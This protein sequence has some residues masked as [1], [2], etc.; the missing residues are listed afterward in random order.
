MK[1]ND[2]RVLRA[3]N[4]E[5]GYPQY[6]VILAKE[7]ESYAADGTSYDYSLENKDSAC[8][9]DLE[10]ELENKYDGLVF[11]L[12]NDNEICYDEWQSNDNAIEE[13]KKTNKI[14]EIREFAKEWLSEHEWHDEPL[15]WNYFDGSRWVSELLYS[16]DCGV[17]DNKN[18]E[19]L[20][21]DDDETKKVVS[22]YNRAQ[23]NMPTFENGYATYHDKETGYEVRFSQWSGH[24]SMA[25]VF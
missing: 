10:S 14:K 25:D 16:A 24:A 9:N 2:I 4:C 23:N 7:I 3:N 19:L 18:Y 17:S 15:Y 11:G 22:A 6:L 8:W 1:R 21:E 13:A 12:E 20:G 5:D